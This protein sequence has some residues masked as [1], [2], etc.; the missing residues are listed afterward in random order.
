MDMPGKGHA[1]GGQGFE[2]DAEVQA[3]RDPPG[4][5]DQPDGCRRVLGE[6]Q[7]SD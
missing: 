5:G 6:V 1:V 3:D 4:Q 2:S 7:T